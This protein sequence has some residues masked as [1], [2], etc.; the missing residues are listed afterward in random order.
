MASLYHIGQQLSKAE[1]LRS[2]SHYHAALPIR[3]LGSP[4]SM[5]RVVMPPT[6]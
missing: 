6:T 4:L 1:L 3:R 5:T 2:M